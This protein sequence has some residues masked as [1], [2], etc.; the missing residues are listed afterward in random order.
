MSSIPTTVTLKHPFEGEDPDD[1][2][3][4]LVC[5]GSIFP[6]DSRFYNE[7]IR[8]T[9][10]CFYPDPDGIKRLKKYIN[11]HPEDLTDK[12]FIGDTVLRIVIENVQRFCSEEIVK[13]LIENG[14]T[15]HDNFF[16]G[17]YANTPMTT[18]K[19]LLD[20][21]P[22]K[23]PY[24]LKKIYYCNSDPLTRIKNLHDLGVSLESLK[25]TLQSIG[26]IDFL[27]ASLVYKTTD[28]LELFDYIYPEKTSEH[29]HL[30]TAP[31][32][33][34][35]VATGTT[36]IGIG[37]QGIIPN[38]SNIKQEF[39]TLLLENKRKIEENTIQKMT[40][41]MCM[42]RHFLPN[43]MKVVIEEKI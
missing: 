27:L 33:S 38:S 40:R 15:V 43:E 6:F 7:A 37:W 39:R 2:P 5:Y 19:I 21:R 3:N 42:E 31:Q 12:N 4:P 32:G 23:I 30:P 18:Y 26:P 16:D 29:T 41:V 17:I 8:L 13:I 28:I 22:D 25:I 1:P 36:S 34:V 35:L 24:F 14:A 20:A 9:K 10:L 11:E